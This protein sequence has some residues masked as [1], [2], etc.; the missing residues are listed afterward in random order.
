MAR[1]GSSFG[2]LGRFGRSEDLRRLD[3]ALRVADLH[4]A[5]VPEGVKLAL[6][7][8]LKD[9]F[10]DE[11]PESAYGPVAHLFGYCALGAGAYAHANGEAALAAATN[12]VDGALSRGAGV[13]AAVVLLAH[14]ARMLQPDVVERHGIDVETD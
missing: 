13:D 5:L 9:H 2:F 10:G 12:R 3:A 14:H 1:R 7:N 8:V 6:V 11:P 4:P